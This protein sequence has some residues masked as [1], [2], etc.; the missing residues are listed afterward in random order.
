M[1]P[2][3]RRAGAL[4]AL[5]LLLAAGSRG[6]SLYHPDRPSPYANRKASRVGD[7]V[8]VLI[9]ESATGQNRT[10]L[11]T[12]KESQV[13]MDG[14]PWSGALD[15]LPLFGGK[16]DVTDDLNGQGSQTLKGDLQAKIT[17]Q[18]VEVLPGGNLVL[19]GTRRIELNGDEDEI[20]LRGI[21]RP[22]DITAANTVLSTFLADAQIAYK[23]EGAVR[24]T[25]HRGIFLRILSWFF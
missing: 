21:V 1:S 18:V 7:V 20:T 4:A 14:G 24:H 19:E 23:G 25:G 15:F 2:A 10:A 13:E 3:T 12:T 5:L 11:R 8:T 9:V 16:M 22:E 17:A 6:T